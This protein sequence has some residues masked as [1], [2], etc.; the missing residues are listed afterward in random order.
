[1]TEQV[2][3]SGKS[4]DE[5]AEAYKSE[6]WWYDVRGFF[7]LT[8][9][10]NSTLG[11]QL[12][13]FGPNF[14]PRHLEVACGTGTLLELVLRWRRWK[15]LPSVHITG[16]D[17]AES[18]LAGARHRF[19]RKP[20]L[21][22]Q[23]ADA[24]ALPYAADRFDTAN[25]ANSVHSFPDVDGALKDI[26]RVLRPGGTLAA[27]VLLYPRG[28]WPLRRIAERINTWGMRKGILYT[29][30]EHDDIRERFVRAGFEVLADGVSGNCCNLLLR[31]PSPSESGGGA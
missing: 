3:H 15:R 30:Y 14:G 17:Y 1:M 26:F 28:V 5:I 16:V 13:F 21:E 18:M 2:A 6:P 8:F 25:I 23:H 4:R 7:I 20:E 22:F 31:K 24:A 19:R 29:P 11:S 12:R 10:Y 9:A 27:N